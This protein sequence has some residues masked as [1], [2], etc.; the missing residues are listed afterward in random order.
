M[1]QVIFDVE[2]KKTFEQ[3]GGYYPEKLGIS[4]V[5]AIERT[6]FPEEGNV[7]EVRHELFESDLNKLWPVL[8]MA[9][10]IIG[11]NSHGFDLPALQ[12]YYNGDIT[13]LPSLDLM[14]AI[15]ESVGHRIGLDAV[16]QST[17][18]SEKSGTGLDAIVYFQNG[19]LEELA[20]YCMQDVIITRDVYDFGRQQGVVSFKNRW[21]NL[22]EAE[23]DFHYKSQDDGGVQMTLV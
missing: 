5:G 15:K 23:V 22:I 12:P 9:D 10:V 16:A 3:V 17:L 11:F 8:E 18:G 7:I 6:G 2:T 13:K 14:A 1:K 21:N 20:K 19:Q 4:F